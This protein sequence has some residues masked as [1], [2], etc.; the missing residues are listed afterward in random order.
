MLIVDLPAVLN[1]LAEIDQHVLK[2]DLLVLTHKLLTFA[3][4]RE[5]A[6]SNHPAYKTLLALLAHTYESV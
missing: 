2:D 5:N 4:D 6:L 1:I 3:F